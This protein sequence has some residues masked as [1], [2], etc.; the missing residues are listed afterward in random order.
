MVERPRGAAQKLWNSYWKPHKVLQGGWEAPNYGVLTII[1]EV[2]YSGPSVQNW[3]IVTAKPTENNVDSREAIPYNVDC[4]EAIP[5]NMDRREAS[6]F[7]SDKSE[8]VKGRE[9]WCE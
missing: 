7:M 4:R 5:Y 3:S 2:Y 6:M 8:Q 9:G 1:L